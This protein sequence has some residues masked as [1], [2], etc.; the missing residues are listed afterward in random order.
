MTLSGLLANSAPMATNTMRLNANGTLLHRQL[1]VLLQQQIVSG[2]LRSGERLPTQEALCRQFSVSR[3]TV[4]KALADLQSEGLI[5]NEQ[6][7]GAFVTAER[8]PVQKSPSLGFVDELHRVLAETTVKVMSIDKQ[9]CPSAVAAAL[10]LGESEEALHVVRTRARGRVPVMLLDAWIP[11]QY[12]ASVTRKALRTTP[13]YLLIAGSADKL[14]R[15]AQQVT[16]ALADPVVAEALQV[17]M[18]SAVL[19]IERL[20]HHRSGVPIQF[21]TIWSTS[22]RSRLVM[23]LA[24]EDIDG[25]NAGRLL[26][27]VGV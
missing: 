9:R 3:I 24:A 1:F 8:S 5:R 21:M 12:S 22:E 26:H 23:E 11:P 19:K 14:G 17:D 10:G 16:A 7:V 18:N 2:R 25:L 20:I 27:D 6:G 4:R 13:L 15:V